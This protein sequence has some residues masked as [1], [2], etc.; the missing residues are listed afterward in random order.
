MLEE[1]RGRSGRADRPHSLGSSSSAFRRGRTL[2]AN[3]S[4]SAS[5]TQRPHTSTAAAQSLGVHEVG[6]HLG[7]AIGNRGSMPASASKPVAA[8][9]GDRRDDRLEPAGVTLDVVRDVR[10]R[11][12]D[13][14]ERRV[15]PA[16]RRARP[17]ARTR[18]CARAPAPT[19][20]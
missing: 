20:R 6:I 8:G 4:A 17:T 18:G 9:L 11:R 12:H 2:R 1:E 14:V 15:Q 16:R 13:D 19:P 7:D 10:E 5:L 3:A